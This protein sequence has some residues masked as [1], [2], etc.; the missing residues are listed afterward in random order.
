MIHPELPDASLSRVCDLAWAAGL[1]EGEGT[2]SYHGSP[3]VC[4]TTT[5]LDVLERFHAVMSF[6][7][8]VGPY[9]ASYPGKTKPYWRWQAYGL[10][11]TQATIAYFWPYLGQ[12]R[13]ERYKEILAVSLA[14]PGKGSPGVKRGPRRKAVA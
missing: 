13:R 8:L 11:K 14:R 3:Y 1:F 10:E 5:D 2:V 12:R 4:M 6:G 9:E 7:T